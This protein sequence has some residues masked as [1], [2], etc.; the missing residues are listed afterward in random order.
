LEPAKK[1]KWLDVFIWTFVLLF[2]SISALRNEGNLLLS[3]AA[4]GGIIF[5][6]TVIGVL[7]ELIIDALRNVKAV[8]VVMGFITNGP[9]AIVL[10]I[11]IITR[12]P[13]F[14]VSTPL[15]SNIINP[16]MFILAALSSGLLI[17]ALKK[18]KD[19]LFLGIILTLFVAL[20]FYL[21]PENFYPLW[22]IV[23]LVITL[24]LFQKKP[25]EEVKE[26]GKKTSK[27]LLIPTILLL[28]LFGYFLDITVEF[29]TQVSK[30]PKNLI[31]FLVLASLSSWPEFKSCLSFFKKG[32]LKSAKINIIVSGI[33][34]IWLAI[35][36]V[37]FYVIFL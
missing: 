32:R 18:D 8:A 4:S 37:L 33:T 10:I 14:G 28:I 21:V 15:G 1:D 11:G 7:V 36:G 5:I 17:K 30:T 34:N 3:I 23:S 20:S 16:V 22:V 26:K 19:F 29:A 31:G 25:N 9:E 2:F 6:M 35:I 27:K 24:N 13:L 12:D